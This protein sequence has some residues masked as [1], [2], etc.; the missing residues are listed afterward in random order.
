MNCIDCGRAVIPANGVENGALRVGYRGSVQICMECRL[1][2]GPGVALDLRLDEAMEEA[3]PA[4]KG[5]ATAGT[6]EDL[7]PPSHVVRNG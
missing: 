6:G 1:R 4:P 5:E 7:P 3:F 2:Y